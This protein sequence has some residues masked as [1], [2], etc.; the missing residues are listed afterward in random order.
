MQVLLAH[1]HCI[2]PAVAILVGLALMRR[3]PRREERNAREDGEEAE[4]L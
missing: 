3:A 4:K 1:W 2:I